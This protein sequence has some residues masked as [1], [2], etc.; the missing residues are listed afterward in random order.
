[1]DAASLVGMGEVAHDELGLHEPS[2]VLQGGSELAPSVLS[3]QPPDEQAG[4]DCA[5]LDRSGD[6]EHLVPL[7]G[8]QR[9]V[10]AVADQPACWAVVAGAGVPEAGVDEPRKP[11]C[12][13]QAEEVEQREDDVAVASGIGAM[14]RDRQW[15]WRAEANLSAAC[16]IGVSDGT[17]HVNPG[18]LPETAL[19]LRSQHSN[20]STEPST[21]TPVSQPL[22]RPGRAL[23]LTHQRVPRIEVR[24]GGLVSDVFAQRPHDHDSSMCDGDAGIAC[25]RRAELGL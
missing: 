11:G 21:L 8:D 16:A 20:S 24:G 10:H 19:R 2:A 5:L 18:G 12:E 17:D 13:L 3:V 6:V 1:V 14:G 9:R 22:P 7:L 23:L 15:A 4:G 25:G